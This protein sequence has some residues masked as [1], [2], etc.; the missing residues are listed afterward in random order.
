M[1]PHQG[2]ITLKARFYGHRFSGKLRISG[3]YS[4][5]GTTVFS[6]SGNFNIADTFWAEMVLDP[7]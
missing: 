2:N 1:T 5:D 7:M 6:N 3:Q 4:Y